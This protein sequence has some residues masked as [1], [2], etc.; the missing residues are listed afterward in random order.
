MTSLLY[1][2]YSKGL[3]KDE[4]ILIDIST[5]ENREFVFRFIKSIPYKLKK[6]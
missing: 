6:N 4:A 1:I 3:N 2:A 5:C